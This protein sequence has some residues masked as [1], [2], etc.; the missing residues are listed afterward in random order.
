MDTVLFQLHTN[1]LEHFYI[2]ECLTNVM[3]T[4]LHRAPPAGHFME[5][6]VYVIMFKS[7]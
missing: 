4:Y 3:K 2:L 1:I 7:V 5:I 6:M